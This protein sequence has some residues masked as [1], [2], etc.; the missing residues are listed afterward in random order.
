MFLF[1]ILLCLGFTSPNGIALSLDPIQKNL[2]SASALVG[3]I[4]I[5]IAGLTSGGIGLLNVTNSIPVAGM[6]VATAFISFSILTIG[7]KRI[8]LSSVLD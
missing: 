8:N 1:L 7:K 3:T 5:G 4:R 2:G 6:M